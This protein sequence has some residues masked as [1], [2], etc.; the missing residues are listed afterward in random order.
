EAFAE[1]RAINSF[2]FAACSSFFKLAFCFISN[3]SSEED[4]Q[5]E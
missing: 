1:K 4:F 2:S 5:N 3:K